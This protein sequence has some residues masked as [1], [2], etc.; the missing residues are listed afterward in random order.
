MKIPIYGSRMRTVTLSALSAAVSN[1]KINYNA[2]RMC[3]KTLKS[4]DGIS[5]RPVD[6]VAISLRLVSAQAVG[7]IRMN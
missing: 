3:P 1:G 7:Q 6:P 5:T 2:G 4:R